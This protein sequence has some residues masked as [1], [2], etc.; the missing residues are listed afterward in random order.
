MILVEVK[1]AIRYK[2]GTK[3]V[4]GTRTEKHALL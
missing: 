4:Q 1:L 3:G 2:V